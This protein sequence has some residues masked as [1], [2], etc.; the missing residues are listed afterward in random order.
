MLC[1]VEDERVDVAR[2]SLGRPNASSGR[3]RALRA[4]RE[5]RPAHHEPLRAL[6]LRRARTRAVDDLDEHGD[7]VAFS[8]RLAQQPCTRHGS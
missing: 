2:L 8:D 6:L 3:R 1:D 4:A 5:V 7:P